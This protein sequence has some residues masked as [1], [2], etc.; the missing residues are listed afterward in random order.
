MFLN[1]SSAPRLRDLSS[2]PNDLSSGSAGGGG[3]LGLGGCEKACP[4]EDGMGLSLPSG[5]VPTAK[6]F[7]LPNQLPLFLRDRLG[8]TLLMVAGEPGLSDFRLSDEDKVRRP[9]NFLT[10]PGR[11]LDGLVGDMV[12]AASLVRDWCR[13]APDSSDA[14]PS[15]SWGGKPGDL[16]VG[17]DDSGPFPGVGGRG[18]STGLSGGAGIEV[19]SV[20]EKLTGVSVSGLYENLLVGMMAAVD[21]CADQCVQIGVSRIELSTEDQ[22]KQLTAVKVQA[23]G[24]SGGALSAEEDLDRVAVEVAGISCVHDTRVMGRVN[25]GGRFLRRRKSSSILDG[26]RSDG[27]WAMGNGEIRAADW[28]R[29]RGS[30]E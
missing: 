10:E 14:L 11:L 27:R 29:G 4:F 3:P 20:R 21:H 12:L 25:D 2:T 5:T 8:A 9:R 22:E 1:M 16:G 13:R 17:C 15:A 19:P 7:F 30:W 28:S 6:F 23:A 24:S 18:A 26:K